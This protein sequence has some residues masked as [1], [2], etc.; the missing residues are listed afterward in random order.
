MPRGGAAPC[1]ATTAWDFEVRHHPSPAPTRARATTFEVALDLDFAGAPID[2]GTR[3]AIRFL[4]RRF[5]APEA[6]GLVAP[7]VVEDP[8]AEDPRSRRPGDAHGDLPCDVD[9]AWGFAPG[10]GGGSGV[11]RGTFCAGA[12]PGPP[13][14]GDI[15][16]G[17]ASPRAP[18]SSSSTGRRARRR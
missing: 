6:E 16:A 12:F 7:V 11:L 4:D 10:D 1:N 14:P 3:V 13:S 18:T 17:T 2:Y 5:G 15:G 9:A 8:N